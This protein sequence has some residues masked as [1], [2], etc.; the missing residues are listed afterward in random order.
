MKQYKKERQ[1]TKAILLIIL[2]GRLPESRVFNIR[3]L[4]DVELPDQYVGVALYNG[5]MTGLDNL[6]RSGDALLEAETD[7]NLLAKAHNYN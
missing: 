6:S 7:Q 4:N 1:K 5:K 2:H 3:G